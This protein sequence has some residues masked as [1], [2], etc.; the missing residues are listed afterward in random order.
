MCKGNSSCLSKVTSWASI[1][2]NSNSRGAL[3]Q[4]SHSAH[5]Q[6]SCCWYFMVPSYTFLFLFFFLSLEMFKVLATLPYSGRSNLS[7]FG[8]SSVQQVFQPFIF[9]ISSI[10]WV[11]QPFRFWPRFC[12]AGVPTFHIFFPYCYMV[13]VPTFPFCWPYFHTVG[14]PTSPVF[15]HTSIHTPVGMTYQWLPFTIPHAFFKV[16]LRSK[17]HQNSHFH[18]HPILLCVITEQPTREQR[19]QTRCHFPFKQWS[20]TDCETTQVSLL[21][22]GIQWSACYR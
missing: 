13:D 8:H 11:F 7:S 16:R 1:C 12:T 3:V 22:K 18:E 14:F 6:N 20:C 5:Q 15:G 10:P 2:W 17:T 19:Q 4:K 21:T 9:G